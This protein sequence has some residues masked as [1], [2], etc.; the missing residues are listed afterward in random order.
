MSFDKK[1]RLTENNFSYRAMKDG[2]IFLFWHTRHIKTLKGPAAQK[3]LQDIAYKDPQEVQL[4]LAKITGNFK[5][6]NER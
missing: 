3:F 5:H 4:V 1:Q 6:G 2:C